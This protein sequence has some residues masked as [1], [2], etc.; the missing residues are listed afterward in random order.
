MS[1]VFLEENILFLQ[2]S[3]LGT[4]KVHINSTADIL[5]WSSQTLFFYTQSCGRDLWGSHTC[6]MYPQP[7]NYFRIIV[8]IN[9]PQCYVYYKACRKIHILAGG[10]EIKINTGRSSIT[11]PWTVLCTLLR[12]HSSLWSPL[13]LKHWSLIPGQEESDFI[14]ASCLAML[15]GPVSQRVKGL[16]FTPFSDEESA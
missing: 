16:L 13:A 15:H 3:S 9:I 2:P 11:L 8:C 1:Y 12:E 5:C 14:R 10:N 4:G 6:R 7:M